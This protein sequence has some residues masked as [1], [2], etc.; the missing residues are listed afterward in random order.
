MKKLLALIFCLSVFNLCYAQKAAVKGNVLD[1]LNHVKLSNSVVALL[2]AK[3]SV[4]YKFARTNESGHFNFKDLTAGKYLL[5][6]TYPSFAD[7]VEPLTLSDTTV[8]SYDKIMLTQKSRLLQEV[9]IQQKIAAIK[10][11][12]DTTEFNADSYKTQA[13][14][15][16]EDL[17]KKLPGIQIDNKGQITAQGETVKKVLVDGEEF[18]GDDPT[19]VTKNLRADMVDKVQLFDKK[20][21]QANFTGVDDGQQSKTINLKLKDSKKNG[22]FGK[23]S[24]GAGTN[25]YHDS[26]AMLNMFKK[27]QKIAV[28]GIVSN[29]GKTGLNWQEQDKYGQSMADNAVSDGS[30][31]FYI[32]GGQDN[33]FQNWS[34]NYNGQGYPLVQ[35]GGL[36]YNNKWNQD[37]QSINGNY[38]MMQLYMDGNNTE[39]TQYILPDTVYYRNAREEFKNSIMRNRINGG[40]EVQL[41]SSST[42]NLRVDGGIDHKISNSRY[43]TAFQAEDS[44][45]VNRNQRLNSSIADIGTLNSNLLWR[46]KLK[47]KGR[48]ISLNI[49]ENYSRTNG[50]GY[51][52]SITEFFQHGLTDSTQLTDQYKTT[53]NENISL[54]TNLTYTEPLSAASS[55]VVNYGININNSHSARNSFNK[56]TD[57]KYGLQDSIY[58][59]DYAFNMLTHKGG[60]AYAYMKKKLRVNVGSNV[61]FTGYHQQDMY[62]DFTQERSFMNWYPQASVRYS[63]SQQRRFSFNYYGNTQQPGINQL[64]PLRANED[65]LNIY[66]GNPELKPSFGSTFRLNYSDFKVLTDRSIWMGVSYGTTS[67]AI[68][69]RSTID[70]GGKRTTQS[71][72]V[73]GN[74]NANVNL[75]MGWKIKKIDLRIGYNMYGQYYKNVS[76]VNSE[77]NI[78]QSTNTSG[79]LYL[80][81]S[82]EKK[83]EQYLNI[84]ANYNTSQSSVQ[85]QIRTNYWTYSIAHNLDLFLPWKL[86]LHSE[87][88]YSIRQKTAFF[89]GNNNVLLWNAW[90]G[91]K[92]GKKD[93]VQVNVSMNDILN[94][95]IGFNRSVNSNY[96]TQNTYS[97]ISR[98]GMLTFIWNFNKVGGGATKN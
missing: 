37:K 84:Q 35:T 16:V 51:L 8:V 31:D 55:L 45:M 73:D 95:N 33:E 15:S 92:F 63:F 57:G 50:D 41:D 53:N 52:N 17:L 90:F 79:G 40:Y 77:L 87:I 9:V 61:G 6:V 83:Y 34:G 27:K 72:N 13:N 89:T 18:F 14:A 96:I 19:L 49:A 47:K 75:N 24:T 98:F 71:V 44:S 7:Y 46:K 26:Q 69:N 54:I 5:L 62:H 56:G 23:V 36:H 60:L 10:I 93:V 30:G 20:S 25:G 76:F 80:Y 66:I 65:P 59:N 4:L 29:T 64:Q 12:G 82:K 86:Q 68:S 42:I 3:D 21:D 70:E 39:A 38:K 81:K 97:T 91:K 74:Q 43:S 11:K 85:K 58:S 48:T 1:T 67:N 32:M 88:N 94:Q 22:Y 2:H 28:Y 78:T